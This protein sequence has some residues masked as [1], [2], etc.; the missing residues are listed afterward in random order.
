MFARITSVTKSAANAFIHLTST[1]YK[2]FL[3]RDSGGDHRSA[4]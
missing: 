4:V 3:S 2:Q 1:D